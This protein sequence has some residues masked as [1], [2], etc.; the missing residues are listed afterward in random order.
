MPTTTH[1]LLTGADLHEPKGAA[2]ATTGT[3]Y[4]ANG[5]GS[6]TWTVPAGGAYGE[7]YITGGSATQTLSAA[8]AYATLN[9][10]SWAAGESSNVTLTAANGS[11]T[12]TKAGKYKV[13]FWLHFTTAAL[14]AGTVYNFK[15]AI[16]GVASTRKVTVQKFTNGADSLSISASGIVS[17][18]ANDVLTIQVAGDGTSSSTLITPKEAGLSAVL[19]K[20]A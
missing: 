19:L 20:V 15:Y 16:N 12:L 13:E 8:S 18:S 10:T 3:V 6:G 5:S 9:A 2:T 14:A 17:V 11:L 7:L 1:S 4:T